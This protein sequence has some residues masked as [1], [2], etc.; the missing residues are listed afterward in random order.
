MV[1]LIQCLLPLS[2]MS[3]YIYAY[4]PTKHGKTVKLGVTCDLKRRQSTFRQVTPLG[5]MVMAIEVTSRKAKR[6][7]FQKLAR[8]RVKRETFRIP[9]CLFVLEKAFIQSAYETDRIKRNHYVLIDRC[10]PVN[11]PPGTTQPGLPE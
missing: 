4:K 7:L 8:Y 10:G 2:I 1:R 9:I 3:L 6:I 11:V 5:R